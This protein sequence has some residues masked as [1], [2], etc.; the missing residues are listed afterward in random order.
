MGNSELYVSSLMRRKL[1]PSSKLHKFTLF[2]N[3]RRTELY[4][5]TFKE[6]VLRCDNVDDIFARLKGCN[7]VT[8]M[9]LNGMPVTTIEEIKLITILVR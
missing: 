9:Q 4:R 2:F 6:Y 8:N 5:A 3:G 7:G 1:E